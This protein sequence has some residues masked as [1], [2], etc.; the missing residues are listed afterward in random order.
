[1]VIITLIILSC[2]HDRIIHPIPMAHPGDRITINGSGFGEQ[3]GQGYISLVIND[4]TI[5]IKQVLSWTDTQIQIKLPEDITSCY[6][7]VY[8]DEGELTALSRYMVVY[9]DNLPTQPY[10]YHVP[11]QKQSPWPS[12]RRDYQNSGRSDIIANY[13]E[14]DAPWTYQ[15]GKGIFSSPIIDANGTVYVGSADY[16]FYAI[17]SDGTVRWKMRTGELIDS[18]ST[19]TR[20]DPDL[21]YPKLLLPSGDGYLYCM[22][23]DDS[24]ADPKDR[25]LWKFAA[26]SVQAP[27]YD[28]DW[29]EGNVVLGPDGSIYAG[30]SNFNFYALNA[31]GQ[32]KWYYSA[33]HNVWSAA[34]F[35]E[36]GT[37]YFT[38]VDTT[39]YAVTPDGK[40][41]WWKETLG[42]ISSSA[43]VGSDG[44][45]YFT[46]FDSYLYAINPED[47]STKWKFGTQ[48]HI[49]ATPAL[50]ED[51]NGNTNAIYIGSTDGKLYKLTTQGKLEWTYDT[52]DTIRSSVSI[53][54][55]PEDTNTEILY[56]GCGNG[57]L[58]AIHAAD[59]SRRWSFDTTPEDPELKDR[60]D[61][62]ASP[63]LGENG[64]YICGEHGYVVYVPY[65]YCLYNE[66]ERC[67][68]SAGAEFP[69]N[70]KQLYFVTSG[71]SI[72]KED[73]AV[74]DASST[75]TQRL[76]IREDGKSIDASLCSNPIYTPSDALTITTTPEFEYNVEPSADGRFIHII[77]RE[78]LS[79]GKAYSISI[80]GL[81][82]T[83]GW[84]LGNLVIGGSEAGSFEDTFT[85]TAKESQAES[86]PLT[87]SENQVT[88]L[89]FT[90]MAA[91]LP[92]MLPSLNQIG[93][94]TYYWIMGTL[95]IT[96]PNASQ[97]GSF[98]MWVI[99]A[100][101]DENGVLNIS[102][103]FNYLFPL[104]GQYKNDFFT[105][106]NKSFTMTIA[107]IHIPFNIFQLRGQLGEDL[108]VQPGAS[109]YAE[110]DILDIPH[111]GYLMAAAGLANNWW[112]K[113]LALGTYL[114]RPYDPLGSANK[115]PE[116][117]SVEK[118]DLIP[119]SDF[120][121]GAVR[122]IF[123]IEEDHSYLLDKHYASILL[124]ND[125]TL[126]PVYLDY[127]YS[128][129][130]APD[131]DGNIQK[132]Y[133]FI[134]AG[135]KMPENLGIYVILDVFPFYYQ[136]WD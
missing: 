22:I 135:T 90:R 2:E 8:V 73:P 16:Y 115:R 72:L 114:T 45:I 49:Y 76:I 56:F 88:A 62:N 78:I 130:N 96:D 91:P 104:Y 32:L 65:D 134:P 57:K 26:S 122:V 35:A 136:V 17:N 30:N 37:I 51:T 34:A 66:D 87:V 70:T 118:V 64:V 100:A 106:S 18:A 47:G 120:S 129:V 58:Y 126:E 109:A 98:L 84:K 102:R 112:E 82:Y 81:Y 60:N 48:N 68:I 131:E 75:V 41:K 97:E 125:N 7:N 80:T 9:E 86:V 55:S 43:A 4:Q 105:L 11:V 94:D 38:S 1:M 39:L 101:F 5:D 121:F 83:G 44:T 40:L 71:G 61:L 95:A 29:W 89:E 53:G 31:D 19:L 110:A 42:S 54:L 133:L 111:H 12:F 23:L 25:I 59:G 124:V 128:L 13:Q 27:G 28:C 46:S 99:G 3:Q 93:F 103:D 127:R 50:G 85:F 116:G 15:T 108:I 107:G 113:L 52:G 119:P 77:P 117:I 6:L 92:N 63:A 36:D 67:D 14:E 21:G 10:G 20:I 24:I 123:S 79:P 74:V 33:A 132:S 69:D